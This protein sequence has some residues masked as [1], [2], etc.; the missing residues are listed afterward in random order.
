[1]VFSYC[2]IFVRAMLDFNLWSQIRTLFWLRFTY[3]EEL[4]R[5]LCNAALQTASELSLIVDS[6]VVQSLLQFIRLCARLNYDRFVL[7][8]HVWLWLIITHYVSV[9]LWV[10]MLPSPK[11]YLHRICTH[12]EPLLCS[13]RRVFTVKTSI[14]QKQHQLIFS[15]FHHYLSFR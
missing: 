3:K 9:W 13:N 10:C 1:M 6:R 15:Y 5:C 8:P 11:K 2:M 12:K 4:I 14:M 7:V